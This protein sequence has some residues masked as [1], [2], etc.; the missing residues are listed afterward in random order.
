VETVTDNQVDE[1]ILDYQKLIKVRDELDST[2]DKAKQRVIELAATKGQKSLST[3]VGDTRVVATVT[4]RT[5]TKFNEEG[6]KKALGAISYKRL[7]KL[8]IDR[9]KLDAAIEKNE[10]DPVIVAQYTEFGQSAI[11]IRLTEKPDE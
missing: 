2:I 11:S 5:T 10:V 4:S 6:L 3:R 9:A 7:C 1:A 8:V